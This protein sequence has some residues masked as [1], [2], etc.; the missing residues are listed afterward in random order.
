[1]KIEI[2]KTDSG[3]VNPK[4]GGTRLSASEDLKHSPSKPHQNVTSTTSS[5]ADRLNRL[6]TLHS[7]KDEGGGEEEKRQRNEEDAQ[8]ESNHRR[9]HK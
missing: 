8:S 6:R 2:L 1:M 9:A 3:K 5:D 7:L 4:S